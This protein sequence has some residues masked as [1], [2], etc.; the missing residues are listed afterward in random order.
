MGWVEW[1]CR[2]PRLGGQ[3][4]DVVVVVWMYHGTV[5]G[6]FLLLLCSWRRFASRNSG[7][8]ACR[9]RLRPGWMDFGAVETVTDGT[10]KV[11]SKS[12]MEVVGGWMVDVIESS[13]VMEE[14]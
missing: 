3:G 12:K 9:F 4:R 6:Y 10:P 2:A 8:V 14:G 11:A 5:L 7:G 13:R 1:S